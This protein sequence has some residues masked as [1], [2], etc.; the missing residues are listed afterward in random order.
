[1]EKRK[2]HSQ[3]LYAITALKNINRQ[4][5]NQY[6]AL[7]GAAIGATLRTFSIQDFY[8]QP[9]KQ[10]PLLDLLQ[11]LTSAFALLSGFV[12][13][14]GGLAFSTGSATVGAIGAYLGRY[15][16]DSTSASVPQEQ[17]T[18]A[19]ESIYG[20]L[21]NGLDD[22]ATA[23][24]NGSTV[25]GDFNI[26][27][28]MEGGA[29]LDTSALQRVSDLEEKLK[30]EI[31]SRSINALWK[32]PTSN[33]IFVTFVDLGE[34]PNSTAICAQDNTG[35]QSLKYC[36]DGGVYYTHNPIEDSNG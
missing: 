20:S 31:I 28:M 3:A 6:I 18:D 11:G 16:G 1:M 36:A 29:W 30:I 13:G 25:Y 8:P 15:I 19:V 17:Y 34:T 9:D 23:L 33:K 2:D 26:L 21:V 5:T 10:F 14:A 7:K 27:Q 24:F 35:P 12:P 32:T 4:L 22:V